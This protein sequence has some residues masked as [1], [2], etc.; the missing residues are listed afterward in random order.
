MERRGEAPQAVQV[1]RG[2]RDRELIALPDVAA[3]DRCH[4]APL[5]GGDGL[6]REPLLEGSGRH[7]KPGQQLGRPRL[8]Q[9]KQDGLR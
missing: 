5:V 8:V 6:V 2:E 1:Q 7:P 3:V 9:P 4:D